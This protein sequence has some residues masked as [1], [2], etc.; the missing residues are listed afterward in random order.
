MAKTSD[1]VAGLLGYVDIAE[2]LGVR[3]E[4]V[5]IYAHS[6][7]DFP[8][9]AT[10][11]SLRSPGF[12]EADVG[13]YARLRI[14]RRKGKS[15]TPPRS[16]GAAPVND[17]ELGEKVRTALGSEG[18]AVGTMTDLADC[19]GLSWDA[20][21]RRINGRTRWT[22]RDVETLIELFGAQALGR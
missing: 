18:S 19:L 22:E 8:V 11:A 21:R 15:G 20:V 2:K 9:P 7:P 3:V 14:E 12:T 5:R 10:P 1:T 4:S 6:D 13:R 16:A 17:V